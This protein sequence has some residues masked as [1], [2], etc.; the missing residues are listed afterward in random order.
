MTFI[1]GLGNPGKQYEE[2]RHNVGFATSDAIAS[3]VQSSKYKV[4]KKLFAE[5]V[6]VDDLILAK[7]TT[8]MNESGKAVSAL[9]AFYSNNSNSQQLIAN[10]LYVIHDDLDITLGEYKIQF[11]KGPK[12]HNGLNSIYQ[13]LGTDQFWHVRIGVDGRGGDRTIAGKNYVL[14][15]FVGEEKRTIDSVIEKATQDLLSKIGESE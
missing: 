15:K 7:P 11:G 1:I 6:K 10:S 8:Y 5:V 2:T 12:I 3:K 14:G 13:H 9:L 4:Q